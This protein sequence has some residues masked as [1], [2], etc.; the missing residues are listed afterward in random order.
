MSEPTVAYVVVAYRSAG[1]LPACLDSISADRPHGSRIIVVDN[2]SPDDSALVAERHPSRP[3]ILRNAEN[4]G[5]GR[6]CNQAIGQSGADLVFLVNPDA[7]LRPDATRLLIAAAAMDVGAVGP[8][9]VDPAGQWSAAAAGFEPSMR[10]AL[11]HFLLLARVPWIGR[12]FP[13]FQLSGRSHAQ[14]VDWVGGAAMLVRAE[15]FRDVGGFDPAIF[16]YGEDIDLCRRLRVGGFSVLYE[17]QAVVD[18]DLGGS[19]GLE[20]SSRWYVALHAY[21][22]RQRGSR[23]ARTFSGLAA[24]GLAIRAIAFA[25]PRPA[26]ARRMTIAART[27]AHCALGGHG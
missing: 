5:F 13:P 11:G 4:I 27:A 16:L 8:R 25:V 21:V 23:Y 20:Q 9:I 1:D 7:R 6:A 14:S 19:Q 3:E 2:A 10:S 12:L 17:P 24:I 15:P 18:H 26:Q 22:A